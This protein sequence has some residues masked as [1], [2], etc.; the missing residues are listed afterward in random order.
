MSPTVSL[1]LGDCLDVLRTLPAGSVDAVVTSP[2]Y[3]T[4]PAKN[5]PSGLH[6]ERKTGVNKWIT[7][8]SSGYFDQRPEPEY[9]EWVRAVVAECLRVARGLVWVNH[10]TRYR[11]KEAIHP[12]RMFPFPIYADVVW[13]RRG[14]MALNCKRY[15]PSHEYLIA[16]GVPHYWDDKQNTMMSVWQI[17]PQRSDDHPCPFPVELARRPIVSSCPIGGTV[18]DPFMGSGTTGVAC[19]KTGR[20]FIGI[21]IDPHYHAIARRRI[22]AALTERASMLPLMTAEVA[23]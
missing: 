15:A 12:A 10:K 9:Q 17:T 8:A 7:K 20:N 5:A 11:N 4:L 3:N 16:F 13:D 18:L 14:S 2:P 6:A 23:S 1:H 19:V 22:D 21:E